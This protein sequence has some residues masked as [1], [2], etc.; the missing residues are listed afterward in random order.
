[1]AILTGLRWIWRREEQ[2]LKA[3]GKVRPLGI[4]SGQ[5]TA[6][7][8]PT[9]LLQ[10]STPQ[11]AAALW[12]PLASACCQCHTHAQLNAVG[13]WGCLPTRQ[14]PS[15]RRS[16]PHSPAVKRTNPLSIPARGALPPGNTGTPLGAVGFTKLQHASPHRP[17]RAHTSNNL[18]VSSWHPLRKRSA[19]AVYACGHNNTEKNP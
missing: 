4:C 11:V 2:L 17:V 8:P 13:R 12:C 16:N 7:P 3:A 19:R 18:D 1:V 14:L 9:T 10:A 5:R 15:L 6:P